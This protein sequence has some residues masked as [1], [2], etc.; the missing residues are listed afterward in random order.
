MR[1]L[2]RINKIIV[3]FIVGVAAIALNKVI[4]EKNL[5]Y[6][7]VG[8]STLVLAIE[9]LFYDIF[10]RSY[11][12]DHNHIGT[13]LFKIALSMVVLFV[14]KDNLDMICICWAILVVLASTKT[15]NKAISHMTNKEP[16]VFSMLFSIAQLVLS[17]I[18]ITNPEEHAPL[19][20]IILGI[21]FIIEALRYIVNYIYRRRIL[22]RIL[23]HSLEE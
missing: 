16:F 12:T 20:V 10:T 13:E 4:I 19:H 2:L 14:L 18:L 3:Y 1:E 7:L 23:L 21:E 9:G 11:K 22:A 15:L 6:L 5:L 17:V 8:L